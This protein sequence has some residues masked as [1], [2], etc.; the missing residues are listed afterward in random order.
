MNDDTVIAT[1]MELVKANTQAINTMSKAVNEN[2]GASATMASEMVHLRA[3]IAG[4][5]RKIGGE[6]GPMIDKVKE[7]QAALEAERGELRDAK[8]R[9]EAA[10]RSGAN[11]GTSS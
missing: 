11:E 3:T 4:A 9:G 5:Q 2:A 7:T 1:L 6:I 10:R 8:T